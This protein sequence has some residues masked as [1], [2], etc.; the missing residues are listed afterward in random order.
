MSQIPQNIVEQAEK[1]RQTLL[2]HSWRYHVQDT[3]EITDAEYDRLY[4]EL[5]ALEKEYP[6]L[7]TPDS[8]TQKVGG[9]VLASL[10][11]QNHSLR[12]YS[13]DNVFDTDEWADYVQRT[14]K[15]LP[16]RRAEDLAF[17][18]EPKM[19]GLAMELIYENGLLTTALTRGDGYKGEVVTENIKTIKNVPLRL[20]G[21]NIPELLEVRG[22]VVITHADF[23]ALNKKQAGLGNKIFANQR[24][25]AAGSVR[26]LDSSVAA[27]RPLR[28]MAYGIGFHRFA[29]GHSF[30]SQSEVMNS[31]KEYGLAVAPDAKLCNTPDEV[32]AYYNDLGTRRASL[33][34]DIDGV[35]AKLN[36]I[37]WQ[38]D[39]GFTSHAPR[40]AMAL[41][42]PAQQ[43]ETKLLSI[44]VNVGRTGAVTPVAILE[45]VNVGGVVVSRAT[46]HNED[47]IRAKDLLIGD[48]VIIQRA[49]D[50]IPEVV[51]SIAEKRDGSEQ[52]FIFPKD[53]PV[54]W[55]QIHREP[56]EAAWRCVNK[57]CP[58]V[59]KEALMHFVSKAGLDVQG[60]GASWVEILVD[61]GM[62]VTPADLFRLNKLELLKL[63]RMGQR[64]AEKFID[65][66]EAA[67]TGSRLQRLIAALG[68]RHVGE[69]TARSLA[70]AYTDLDALALA[71]V[72]ELQKIPDI[73]PEVANAIVDF[74]A[75]S[76]NREM[77]SD[78]KSLGL[79]PVEEHKDAAETSG[80]PLSGKTVLFT[81][82]LN[83]GRGEAKKKAEAAGAKVV[84]GISKSVDYLVAGEEA[85]SKLAKAQELGVTVLD[86]AAFKALLAGARKDATAENGIGDH[87]Q[88]SAGASV[89]LAEKTARAEQEEP[90]AAQEDPD[91]PA[92]RDG[93]QFSLF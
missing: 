21:D 54:C 50:V 6:A 34:F 79:W 7:I 44:E 66:F 81:G 40:W 77:L 42:F 25:A 15:L 45:P 70:S 16:G 59:R 38:E 43:K 80:L 31:I 41:K 22:E 8:P 69:Q 91:Q 20:R 64:L 49:G 65:A 72:D 1:L 35:V 53:C 67:R 56:G 51:R 4:H 47:E 78:L 27:S 33:I 14:M 13:L 75:D 86:E 11:N 3:P 36:R 24:N 26:Q 73:G 90:S 23:E 71:G 5:V 9:A 82:T 62:V 89:G 29:D 88:S 32:A 93:G 17:W 2:Y 46:L 85:G 60:V 12:M 76:G 84:S 61:K 57:L 83:I 10:P 37:D 92:G 52:E 18:T 55:H 39:L 74:F 28:F 19:D 63:E 58:A 48:T 68:I 87:A 30:A